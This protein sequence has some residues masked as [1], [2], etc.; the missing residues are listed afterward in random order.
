MQKDIF[1]HALICS[2]FD[3]I[4]LHHHFFR[5]YVAIAR[6]AIELLKLEKRDFICVVYQRSGK[7]EEWEPPQREDFYLAYS[8]YTSGLNFALKDKPKRGSIVDQVIETQSPVFLPQAKV[9]GKDLTFLARPVLWSRKLAKVILIGTSFEDGYILEEQ[10]SPLHPKLV[11][12][13][14]GLAPIGR[15]SCRDNRRQ[16]TAPT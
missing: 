10:A 7:P 4:W 12:R 2:H 3:I 11:F 13:I 14:N 6:R 5:S 8:G 15:H 16:E 1:L 9:G